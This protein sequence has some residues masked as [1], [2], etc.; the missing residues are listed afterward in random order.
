[1]MKKAGKTTGNSEA[2]FPGKIQNRHL[3]RSILLRE[4]GSGVHTK[5]VILFVLGILVT[6][7]VWANFLHINETATT[8]GEL[9]HAGEA[10]KV[11]HL[12]GGRVL[13]VMVQNGSLVQKGETLIRLDPVIS[14]YELESIRDRVQQLSAAEIR[15]KAL[16]DGV[17]PNLSML[18]DKELLRAERTLFEQTVKKNRLE[19]EM[20]K[21]QIE[22]LATEIE[23][24]KNSKVKLA[25]TVELVKEELDIRTK[26]KSKGLN[27]RVTL[28]QLEKEYNE[29]LYSLKQV[30]N[31]LKNLREKQKELQNII[32]NKTTQ[33]KQQ[34]AKELTETRTELMTLENKVKSFDSTI[35]AL[36]I[37]APASGY[38]HDLQLH[39]PGEV[40]GAGDILLTLIPTDQPLVAKVKISSKDIGH[41]KVAQQARIRLTTYDSRRYGVLAGKV[42]SISPSALIPS[43]QSAPYYEGI[44]ELDPQY[45]EAN[46]SEITLFSG[47]TLSADIKTG[48][49]S[50]IEYLL[51][52]IYTSTQTSFHER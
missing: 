8:E 36:E 29:A 9:F 42:V 52:P 45:Q 28:L 11:Q 7:L 25:K 22:Q 49:K 48:T 6:F 1:M 47:M 50:L 44:V 5:R 34:Y 33:A 10:V 15:L 40:A 19:Q 3:D 23:Q 26:L 51:K 43:D 4:T 13:E 20:L 46:R 12:V 24:Q 41:V 39:F 32:A 2:Q 35:D 30:P 31:T 14:L 21:N 37:K 17:D 16:L 27:S 18:Q 38:V